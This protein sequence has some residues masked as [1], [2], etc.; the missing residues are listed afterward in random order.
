M[1][2]LTRGVAQSA[3]SLRMVAFSSSVSRRMYLVFGG[4]SS[5]P[6]SS[7]V[8]LYTLQSFGIVMS[9]RHIHRRYI[10]SVV[11]CSSRGSVS[12]DDHGRDSATVGESPSR[13]TSATSAEYC[14]IAR[15]SISVCRSSSA[16]L[17]SRSSSRRI[18]RSNS[19]CSA[20]P[21]PRPSAWI[22]F[23]S[24]AR[25]AMSWRR[26]SAIRTK[27]RAPLKSQRQRSGAERSDA[28]VVR[29]RVRCADSSAVPVIFTADTRVCC[30]VAPR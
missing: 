15:C 5:L 23:F 4:G 27:G 20:G 7:F 13:R 28:R 3:I 24:N 29:S 12:Q 9:R 8:A 10:Q 21:R 11:A 22:D 26:A 1:R 6:Y 16:R 25:I 18:C 17:S 2:A 14:A 19:S 30:V